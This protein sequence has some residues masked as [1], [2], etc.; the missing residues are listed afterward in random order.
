M[1]VAG[2]TARCRATTSTGP[3]TTQGYLIPQTVPLA[4][5]LPP[6]VRS[7]ITLRPLPPRSRIGGGGSPPGSIRPIEVISRARSTSE[8][9]NVVSSSRA[10][11]S[12]HLTIVATPPANYTV[13]MAPR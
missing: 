1:R 7:T 3:G 12:S 4:Q 2:S 11:R 10:H 13:A 6:T 8:S 9:K 5:L